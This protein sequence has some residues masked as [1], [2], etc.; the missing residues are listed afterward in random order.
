MQC[1]GQSDCDDEMNNAMKSVVHVSLFFFSCSIG[2]VRKNQLSA[3]QVG[4]LA[5]PSGAKAR[6]ILRAFRH[7]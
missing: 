4:D 7:G 6:L 5:H 1:A 3:D 2:A